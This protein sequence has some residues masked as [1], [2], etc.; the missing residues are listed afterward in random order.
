[1]KLSEKLHCEENLVESVLKSFLRDLIHVQ[2]MR[3]LYNQYSIRP[4]KSSATLISLE[5]I[6]WWNKLQEIAVKFLI[7]V[8]CLSCLF[9][10]K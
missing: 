4:S 10:L 3:F 8:Q 5:I 7:Q 2:V 9:L 1:M 6:W